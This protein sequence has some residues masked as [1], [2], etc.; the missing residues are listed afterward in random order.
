MFLEKSYPLIDMLKG[1]Y[2]DFIINCY[3]KSYIPLASRES[4]EKLDKQPY[5]SVQCLKN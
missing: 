2:P 1:I 5:A 4:G 3:L